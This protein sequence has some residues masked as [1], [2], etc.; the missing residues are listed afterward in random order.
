M[1]PIFHFTPGCRGYRL[2]IPPVA[3]T[4]HP[5]GVVAEQRVA[6]G[7][8]TRVDA[9][10]LV[11]HVD[12]AQHPLAHP[13]PVAGHQRGAVFEPDDGLRVAFQVT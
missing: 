3:L 11:R 10:V 8:P 6:V 9:R 5:D 12:D 13:R 2:E 7:E 1:Q 4:C